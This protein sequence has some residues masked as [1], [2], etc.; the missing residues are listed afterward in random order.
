MRSEDGEK[1]RERKKEERTSESKRNELG[2]DT[3]SSLFILDVA[4]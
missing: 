3:F 4:T 2:A 1:L